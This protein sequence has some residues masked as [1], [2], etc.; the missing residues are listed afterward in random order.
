LFY[1]DDRRVYRVPLFDRL[2]WLCHG[3]GTRNSTQWPP[4]PLVSLRQIHSDIL[5]VP[6]APSGCVGQGDGLLSNRPGIVLSIRT[7]DCL[8][9]FLIDP[10][11]RAVA[12]IHAGWRGT[13]ADIAAKCVS[14][15]ERQFGSRP[16]D[17]LAAIGP[18]IKECCYEVGFEVFQAVSRPFSA[19][20]GAVSNRRLD[21][22]GA[23][24]EQ[25]AAAGVSPGNIV[26]GAPCSCCNPLEFH[27]FRRDR[28]AGRMVSALGILA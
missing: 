27:S 10:V 20:K 5:L 1:L 13:A 21:L 25:L 17:L 14:R 28:G 3:F 23:N 24:F 18:G 12:A 11:H 6:E 19:Q 9:I 16:A 2:P 7:A 15:M 4:E 8:P 22:H 26:L